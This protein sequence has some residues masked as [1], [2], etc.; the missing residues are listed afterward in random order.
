VIADSPG[1]R[2]PPKAT[3]KTQYSIIVR[4]LALVSLAVFP[5]KAQWV[6]WETSA[7]GN[8]HW[9]R[10]VPGF[11]GLTWT[12][13]DQLARAEGGYLATLTSPEEN[14]FV[15][16]LVDAPQFWTGFNGSG[17]GIGGFQQVGAVEPEGGWQWV[18]GEA[19]LYS[20]WLP[21]QPDNFPGGPTEDR[22]HFWGGGPR[23]ATW[24]DIARDDLNLGGF[25]MESDKSPRPLLSIHLGGV[26]CWTSVTSVQYQLQWAPSVSSTNWISLGLVVVGNGATVCTADPTTGQQQRFYRVQMLP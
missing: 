6:K 9:Y 26:V 22:L 4:I 21:G 20:N 16:R 3:V 23:A 18:A 11:A 17:P 13:A 15:F 2:D 24:N 8:G 5:A 7:G 12:L 1:N 14:A 19:W 10:P 25:V